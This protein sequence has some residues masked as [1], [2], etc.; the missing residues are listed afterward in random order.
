MPLIQWLGYNTGSISAKAAV[1]MANGSN[2]SIPV[3]V[4]VLVVAL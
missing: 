3:L 2:T 1:E 4:K